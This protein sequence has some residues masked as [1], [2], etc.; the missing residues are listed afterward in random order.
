MRHLAIAAILSAALAASVAAQ[1][2]VGAFARAKAGPRSKPSPTASPSP[3]PTGSPT[4][5]PEQRIVTLSQVVKDN[6]NDRNAQAELGVLLV[7]TGKIADGRDRLETAVKLGLSDA[8][9]WFFIGI[10][11]RELGDPQDAV[12][13]FERAENLDPA[14]AAV[15]QNLIDAYLQTNRLDDAY[16]VANRAVQLHPKEAF[17]YG[18]LGTVLLDEGKFEEGRKMLAKALELDPKDTRVRLL[19]ARSYLGSKPPDADKALADFQAILNDEP[20]NVQALHGK[21]EALAAKNDVGGALAALQAIFKLQPDS[22]AAETDIAA[23]YLSKNMIDEARKA[24]EQAAKDH[25]KSV[26]PYVLEATWDS[27]HNNYALAAK[28]YEQ[29]LAIEPN[30]V[31]LL[32]DYGRLL[33]VGLHQPAKAQEAFQRVVALQP[34]NAEGLFWLGQSYA[35]QGRWPKARDQYRRSF[36]IAHTYIGLFNLGLAYYNLK[37]YRQARDAFEALVPHQARER[38]D[39]QLWFVLGDT[40]RLMGD[41]PAAI[42]AYKNFLRLVP[43]GE[44]A[45]KARGYIKQLSR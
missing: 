27:Q 43:S 1:P 38:P 42:A 23:L 8:Q 9:V 13:A 11:D 29:A 26:E 25:P 4:P 24:F 6:P 5:T 34:E 18:A 22:V 36:D 32:F 37:D 20:N 7:S 30:D 3:S 14:N 44:A 16:R 21:A 35:A 28:E 10:A 2:P 41:K 19:V 33:L 39:P 12:R 31:R 40:D 45:A 17:G 15:L